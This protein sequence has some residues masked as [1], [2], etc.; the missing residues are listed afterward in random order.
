MLMLN[1]VENVK[2]NPDENMNEAYV[3]DIPGDVREIYSESVW[4]IIRGLKMFFK[5]L[6]KSDLG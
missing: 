4:G 3:I 6:W 1:W 2:K 5:L